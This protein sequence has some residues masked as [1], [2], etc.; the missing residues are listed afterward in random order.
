MS[1]SFD[2]KAFAAQLPN[3]PGVYRMLDADAAVLYVGKARD[4]KKRVSSYFTRSARDPRIETMLGHTASMEVTVTRTEGEALLLENQLIKSL[5][6]R[7]NV[8]LRD[9]KSYPYIFLSS[10]DT[11]PRLGFHRGPQRL[12]GEYFGPFPSAH[13]VR[14]SLNAMQKLFR[15]RQCE[16]TFF[17]NRS[18]PC[19]Q[20]QIRRC[21]A[22]CVEYITP[23]EYA[24]DV[25]HAR[26][27]L[28]GASHAVVRELVTEMELASA[29]LDFELAADI[30]DRIAS[31]KKVQAQ[32]F[33]EGAK[34][35]A[36]VVGMAA[37]GSTTCIQLL[38]FRSGRN[39]GSRS[40][41][42][43]YE[44]ERDRQSVLQAF[45][46]QHY[47]THEI[48]PQ[49]YVA[50]PV[51][52]RKLLQEV[53]GERAGRKVSLVH[54]P[55][56][57]RAKWLEMA[58]TN[59]AMTLDLHLASHSGIRR[60]LTDLKDLLELE[61]E[62]RRME[63]FDIS[64]TQGEATVASCVVFDPNG[65]VKSDYRRFNISGIEPGDDYGAMRQ[66]LERRYKRLKSGEGK[67][68]DILFVDGGKGQVRQAMD[69]LAELQI[70]ETLIVGVSKGPD[71]RDGEEQ[72]ILEGGRRLLRPGPASPALALIQWAR[73]EAHRFAITGHRQRRG[74][75]RQRS[76]LED[77]PGVGAKR[78]RSLL[79]QFGG[80]QG[81]KGAGVE[82]LAAVDG[83]SREL[84][85]RIY[86]TLHG[87]N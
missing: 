42:P 62:P 76:T 43:R 21:S 14:D 54:N 22:P 40:F 87:G 48:P 78:R 64:H 3:T 19:L 51:E 44:G 25:R 74:K 53:F 81:V 26:M 47:L 63:C 46:A 49:I 73:D 85:Q 33:V 68:P 8:L 1:D 56:G 86:D 29:D 28:T 17:A 23:E 7:Y 83:I 38:F 35:D 69:V 72:L 45:L 57:E 70:E 65:P 66:A 75:A 15:V 34:S 60:R 2:G 36:D 11:Y 16:D 12:Q 71:R 9:D 32:Q 27:F 80:L 13:S 10:G 39:L 4:L 30:R 41:F 20:Y 24:Q 77:I 55:R 31:L 37:R 6:P 82:E 79:T 5:K 58:N 61:D 50:E 67:L 59:A 18:R 52:D 84:A